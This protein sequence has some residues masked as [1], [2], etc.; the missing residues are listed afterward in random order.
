[1]PSPAPGLAPGKYA[2]IDRERRFL[3]VSL[4]STER[5]ASVRK[6]TDRRCQ[7]CAILLLVNRTLTVP[8]YKPSVERPVALGWAVR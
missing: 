6:I 3:L 8:A 7:A 2:R 4:P 1:M 5:P